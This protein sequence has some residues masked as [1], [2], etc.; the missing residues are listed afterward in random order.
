MWSFNK[1][2]LKD[3]C[4]ARVKTHELTKFYV[5]SDFVFFIKERKEEDLEQFHT[6]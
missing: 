3:L 4:K 1:G 5:V 6:Y 2:V